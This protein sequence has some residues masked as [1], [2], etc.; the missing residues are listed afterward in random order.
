VCYSGGFF[1]VGFI[2][3]IDE[4]VVCCA[5]DAGIVGAFQHQ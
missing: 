5:F 2:F 4:V 1:G 3:A